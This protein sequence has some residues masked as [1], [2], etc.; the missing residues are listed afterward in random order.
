[1]WMG[2]DKANIMLDRMKKTL[3]GIQITCTHERPV[4]DGTPHTC[5]GCMFLSSGTWIMCVELKKARVP[6]NVTSEIYIYA[7]TYVPSRPDT[8]RE[9]VQYLI[10][11]VCYS[12][13]FI[14]QNDDFVKDLVKFLV[15]KKYLK[16]SIYCRFPYTPSMVIL[17]DN[18]DSD[19]DRHICDQCL[20]DAT[21]EW[22]G[23]YNMFI[24][25]DKMKT[26]F[27]K[28]MLYVV[29][30]CINNDG[31]PHACKEC[32]YLNGR[33]W[34]MCL[35][36]KIIHVSCIGTKEIPV[37]VACGFTGVCSRPPMSND[38]KHY[39]HRVV[40]FN[41]REIILDPNLNKLPPDFIAYMKTFVSVRTFQI[42]YTAENYCLSP[43][44]G[45]EHVQYSSEILFKQNAADESK[46]CNTYLVSGN[47]S[48]SS[49]FPKMAGP[50]ITYVPKVAAS[51]SSPIASKLC[52]TV[53][54]PSSNQMVAAP[55]SSQKVAAPSSNPV[56]K[57]AVPSSNPAPMV[58]ESGP[59][60]S[61]SKLVPSSNQIVAAPSSS[62]FASKVS[63][64]RDVL[65][66]KEVSDLVIRSMPVAS[67][68]R[69][70]AEIKKYAHDDTSTTEDN[71]THV[72]FEYL[73][74]VEQYTP[75]IAS[76]LVP[77]DEVEHIIRNVDWNI[78]LKIK[79]RSRGCKEY[80]NEIVKDKRG[81][82]IPLYLKTE[83]R[84]MSWSKI[85]QIKGYTYYMKTPAKRA[86]DQESVSTKRPRSNDN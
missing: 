13:I 6:M 63:D 61:F 26:P 57:E 54:G 79:Q 8:L 15:E 69:V 17:S 40:I 42:I 48:S 25:L 24:I 52:Q 82:V 37:K 44:H 68:A 72:S 65:D 34:C 64:S 43:V 27:D 49:P 47:A 83:I 14:P 70:L 29:K 12:I 9:D 77:Y 10:R 23:C 86:R 1:M 4:I 73:K 56:P 3:E 58:V 76:C 60:A 78:L 80:N 11:P 32:I 75:E 39:V 81:N 33:Q 53:A 22:I 85:R 5:E 66:N 45:I 84:K 21:G 59:I 18:A 62:P 36:Q 41:F 74:S 51:S 7:P 16:S 30:S 19:K 20:F 2:C 35:E 50:S 71:D 67:V 28:S 31:S 38:V 55:S 46:Q